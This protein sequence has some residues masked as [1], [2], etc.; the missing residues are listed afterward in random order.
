M[1]TPLDN[2]SIYPLPV[3]I[4]IAW[5]L[6]RQALE[7]LPWVKNFNIS[8]HAGNHSLFST[9]FIHL[10][11]TLTY[12][13]FLFLSFSLELHESPSLP[14]FL[15]VLYFFSKPCALLKRSHL[16][17]RLLAILN[18]LL[19]LSF[20]FIYWDLLQALPLMSIIPLNYLCSHIYECLTPFPFSRKFYCLD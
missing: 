12:F 11:H 3:S 4:G 2:D 5:N 9:P 8:K 20:G 10:T 7:I 17:K 16:L 18:N 13:S 14:C 6:L 19:V 15:W 1:I